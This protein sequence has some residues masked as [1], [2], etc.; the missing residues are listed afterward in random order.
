MRERRRYLCRAGKGYDFNPRSL[1]GATV[2]QQA[3]STCLFISIHAPLR[4]RLVYH[5][6][7]RLY[8]RI[9]IHAPLRERPK[10]SAELD[11]KVQ[12]SI[13]APLRER[14]SAALHH[15][16]SLTFQST[17]PCG[18]DRHW[19]PPPT[20]PADFNPRSLAGAMP[21][22]FVLTISVCYFNPRSLAGATA[23]CIFI[24]GRIDI[25]IHAPLRERPNGSMS[26]SF[27]ADFNP[28]SLAG[29]T[30][31]FAGKQ[32]GLQISIHAPLRERLFGAIKKQRDCDFNPRSLAGATNINH[33]NHS[34]QHISI[35]APLR[36]RRIA[37]VKQILRISYFNPRSLA[38][39]TPRK[40][41]LQRDFGYFNP[42]SLAGATLKA[43]LEMAY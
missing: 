3:S 14:R 25:S 17:L 31:S 40:F 42:R 36:E 8:S 11:R 2:I 33:V 16:S 29:A 19:H 23:C 39:A 13:H 35:H 1:A 41:L 5:A 43:A 18:S 34:L 20:S 15:L 27:M 30:I 22:I 24:S 26:L 10:T 32:K 6:E 7:R 38:G 28:R 37:L 12:I 21:P 9:S 4:E